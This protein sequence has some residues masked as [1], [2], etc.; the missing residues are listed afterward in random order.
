VGGPHCEQEWARESRRVIPLLRRAPTLTAATAAAAVARRATE[1][2]NAALAQP[3]HTRTAPLRKS[4]FS[5]GGSSGNGPPPLRDMIENGVVV[6][7]AQPPSIPARPTSTNGGSDGGPEGY[8]DIVI[9]P[10]GMAVRFR[11]AKSD[12]PQDDASPFKKEN[13]EEVLSSP[14]KRRTPMAPPVSRGRKRRKRSE[15]NEEIRD[16]KGLSYHTN[17][18]TL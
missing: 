3:W 15:D 4:T 5:T 10:S 18:R 6:R 1:D 2:A 16:V 7:P 13:V 8:G 11:E 9:L 17:M 14:K 12:D